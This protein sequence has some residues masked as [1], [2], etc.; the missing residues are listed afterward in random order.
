VKTAFEILN[1]HPKVNTILINIFGGIMK[2][3]IIAE[4]II[5]AAE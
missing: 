5:K 4:G 2:C 1:D 3:N